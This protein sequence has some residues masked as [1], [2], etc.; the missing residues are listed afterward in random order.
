MLTVMVLYGV[1]SSQETDLGEKYCYLATEDVPQYAT[2]KLLTTQNSIVLFYDED[3]IVNV[4]DFSGNFLYGHHIEPLKNGSG[5]M[6]Y[7]GTYLY[8]LS[9]GGTMYVFQE[10]SLVRYFEPDED[11]DAYWDAKKK[12]GG[13]LPHEI[14]N[15]VYF[16]NEAG[17]CVQRF[18]QGKPTQTIIRFP[19]R[20]AMDTVSFVMVL[21][22]VAV[23][24]F[25]LDRRRHMGD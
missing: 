21:G 5:N 6:A 13:T 2:P 18:E 4:Y 17:H 15:A 20:R 8:V 10:D 7:D 12:M 11:P 14:D 23:L 1:F 3:G 19:E 24:T 9:R 16:Y 25:W 22:I